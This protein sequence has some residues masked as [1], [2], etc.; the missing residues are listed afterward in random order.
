MNGMQACAVAAMYVRTYIHTY[1]GDKTRGSRKKRESLSLGLRKN[2]LGNTRLR[3][4]FR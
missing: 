1:L 4:C 3:D 2:C